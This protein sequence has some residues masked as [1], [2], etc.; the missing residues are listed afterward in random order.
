MLGFSR[1]RNDALNNYGS[2]SL[3]TEAIFTGVLLSAPI[4][5]MN[6]PNLRKGGL[7]LDTVH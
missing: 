2:V 5:S 3:E 4:T 1:V 6:L 7:H